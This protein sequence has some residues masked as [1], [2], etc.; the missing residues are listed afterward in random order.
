MG[1]EKPKMKFGFRISCDISYGRKM[2]FS[3]QWLGLFKRLH[4]RH[5]GQFVSCFS[6]TRY[7]N[8][9]AAL[10]AEWFKKN[11]KPFRVYEC[12]V[13]NGW[14]ITTHMEKRNES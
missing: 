5:K 1:C 13:C 11:P 7:L 12:E 3:L 8:K 14:H 10:N 4:K 9:Q 2:L 6:K